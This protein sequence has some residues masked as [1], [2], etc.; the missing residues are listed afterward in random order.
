MR[1][2]VGGHADG[3]AGAAVDEEVREGGGED[4][5]LF[6][7]FV[8]GGDEVDR[9]EVHVGH[10]RRAEV[11]EAGLGVTHGGGW[12]AIDGAEVSLALHEGVTHGPVLGHVDEGRV[13]GLV[14][15]RVVVTHGFTDDLGAFDERARGQDAEGLHGVEDAALGRLEAVA[16][17]GQSAGDDDGHRVVEEGFRHL[18]GDI[19]EFDFFVLGIHGQRVVRLGGESFG[20]DGDA[21]FGCGGAHAGVGGAEGEDLGNIAGRKLDSI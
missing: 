19:H 14:A 8:V 15:V 4:D 12:V 20:K 3:D 5:G 9:A 17:V 10:E 6:A 16:G 2:H 13:D 21:E 7:F 18:G 11:V 1:G